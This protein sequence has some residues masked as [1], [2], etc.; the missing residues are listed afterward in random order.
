V[1][2]HFSVFAWDALDSVE[3]HAADLDAAA[4]SAV[5]RRIR[6]REQDSIS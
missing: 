2:G 4:I 1:S 5:L 6:M 3:P